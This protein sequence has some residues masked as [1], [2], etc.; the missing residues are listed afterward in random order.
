MSDATDP[1]VRQSVHG[2]G[3]DTIFTRQE[4]RSHRKSHFHPFNIEMKKE[5]ERK[6]ERRTCKPKLA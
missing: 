2:R 4:K 6:K 1:V 3:E 5:K